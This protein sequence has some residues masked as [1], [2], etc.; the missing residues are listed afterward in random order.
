L[1]A[2]LGLGGLVT[3]AVG[4]ASAHGTTLEEFRTPLPLPYLLAG[5][6]ATVAVTALLLGLTGAV[7]AGRRRLV[8]LEAESAA[9]I[10]ATAR[11]GFLGLV[12]A[13]VAHGLLGRQVAADNLATVVVW[14]LWIA[15][16]GVVAV[17]V[18]SPWRVVSPWRT[19]YAWLCRVEGSALGH[20]ELPGALGAWP[21]LAGLVVVVGVAENLTGIPR[22][23][24]A[25]AGLV[26]A[27]GGFVLGGSLVFGRAWF[28]R[29]D[30]LEV[31]YGLLGRTAL[32]AIESEDA[33]ADAGGGAVRLWLQVPWRRTSEPVAHRTVAAAVVTAVYTVSFD[34][35]VETRLYQDVLFAARD[36]AGIGPATGVGLYVAGLAAFLAAFWLVAAVTGRL[37]GV[38]R[39]VRTF[40]ASVV[41]I[42]AASHVAH[43]YPFVLANLGRLPH[44]IGGPAIDLTGWL[45]LPAFW[46]SQV[47]LIVSGHLLAVV[48]AHQVVVRQA[49]DAR[50]RLL[51][52]GPLVALMVGY[53]VLSLWIVSRPVVA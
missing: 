49:S 10:R 2:A 14:P 44:P 33:R 21:A 38:D 34:G 23:P 12:V 36:G 53:T 47:G 5:A 18:G 24:A 42:A 50:H 43:N 19:V 48:A 52:H 15:G 7:P 1:G 9:G 27:Y 32:V 46:G 11:L 22:S 51:A 35:F 45:T 26:A 20:R 37:G 41:P 39:P 31:L 40:A 29:A 4:T 3:T 17:L 8:S 6:G 13:A 25:T 28:R 30:P 16:L